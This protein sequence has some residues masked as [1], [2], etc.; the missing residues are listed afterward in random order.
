M[1]YFL[2]IQN[3]YTHVEIALFKD[4]QIVD[5]VCEDKLR[6][7]KNF[8]LLIA[9]LLQQHQLKFSDLS[10]LAVNQG[11]GPFTTL[12]VVIASVNGLSYATKKPLVGVDALD[13]FLA[14]HENNFYPNTVALLNA[15]NQD[16]YF[17]VLRQGL[18]NAEKGYKNINV[19]LHELN[20]TMASQP[21][22]FIGNA[23]ELY[24]KEIEAI[25]GNN[26][27]MPNPM[28]QTVSIQQIGLMGLRYWENQHNVF[29]ELYPLYLK[30]AIISTSS[31]R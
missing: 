18:A 9:G 8:V 25:F 30:Q 26:A 17:G 13:A 5:G 16:V 1:K 29:Q 14:E 6:A 28:P 31:T 4:D 24:A 2:S 27:Y 10:F 22:R 21:I 7:S 15:F 20:E 19:L 12:R 11:P 3:T 23:A